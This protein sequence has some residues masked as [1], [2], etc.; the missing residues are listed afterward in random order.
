VSG[1]RVGGERVAGAARGA[2]LGAIREERTTSSEREVD[3][4]TESAA[5]AG[6]VAGGMR[7]REARRGTRREAHAVTAADKQPQ[8]A[9]SQAFSSCMT[10]KGYTVQ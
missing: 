7:Q 10:A 5:R 8:A 6:A 4:L 9:Y 1:R 3:D 2:A